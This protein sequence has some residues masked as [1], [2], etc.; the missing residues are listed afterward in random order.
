MGCLMIPKFGGVTGNLPKGEHAATWTEVVEALGFSETRKQLLVGLLEA[1][2][3]LRLAGADKLYIDG[4]FATK[5][6]NPKDFDACYPS[7][8]IDPD[9]LDPV[10]MVFEDERAAM[11]E[12]FG[13]ELFPA[14]TYA[15]LGQPYRDFFQT[16]RNGRKKGIVVLDLGTLP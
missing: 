9:K 3:A 10:L 4:S 13:G 15:T 12:K 11:K 6:H 1:A 2:K 16:D 7:A 8:G 14:E 5:K